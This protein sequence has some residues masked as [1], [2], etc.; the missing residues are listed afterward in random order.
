[1]P[2]CEIK[3]TR[4]TERKIKK[5]EGHTNTMTMCEGEGQTMEW[6]VSEKRWKI[7]ATKNVQG[8]QSPEEVARWIDVATSKVDAPPAVSQVKRHQG[9]K[10][11]QTTVKHKQ[12]RHK[13]SC[14]E[15]QE[16]G[17]TN[18]KS[19]CKKDL[20]DKYRWCHAE[21]RPRTTEKKR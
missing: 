14:M 19:C 2:N 3:S 16:H 18:W 6:W 1:M 8:L 11:E 17:S 9:Q 21:G 12:R 15:A 20:E 7:F 13:H 5:R 4:R 10:E